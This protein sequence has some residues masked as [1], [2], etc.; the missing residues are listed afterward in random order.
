VL[1]ALVKRQAGLTALLER[2]ACPAV[3]ASVTFA[4]RKAL[5]RAADEHRLEGVVS[6]R[7]DAPYRSG[8]CRDWRKVKT[9]AW[10]E[11][12]RGRW[13]LCDRARSPRG[14]SLLVSLDPRFL[15]YTSQRQASSAMCH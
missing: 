10:R 5:L 2:F 15:R 12:N 13:R 7:R 11:A 14:R 8:D 3:S 9:S 1:A 6:K 4:D